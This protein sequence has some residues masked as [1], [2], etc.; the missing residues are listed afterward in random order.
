MKYHL[1]IVT[2]VL[3]LAGCEPG[4]GDGADLGLGDLN[5]FVLCEGNY[6]YINASLWR[7]EPDGETV[8]GLLYQGLTGNPLGDVAQSMNVAGDKLYIL[9]TNSHTL[10]VLW[11]GVKI[12]FET[13]IPLPG[14]GPRYMAVKGD[15]GYVTCWGL[16]GILTIDLGTHTVGKDT[17]KL[18]GKPE[19]IV[20]DGENIYCALVSRPDWTAAD[21]VV[22]IS[23][24][25]GT[26]VDS[27]QVV[28]GPTRLLVEAGKLYVASLY[29]DANYYRYAGSSVIDLVTGTVSLNDYGPTVA[30][31]EDLLLFK[32]QVYRQYA[33]GVAP[34]KDDLEVD[35]GATIG[36]LEG[37]YSAAAWGDYLFFGLTDY[38]A[39]DEVVLVD[40]DGNR[41]QS[42]QVGAL[43][44]SFVFYQQ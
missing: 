19:D 20:V 8:E 4:S 36:T 2:L 22:R 44:G 39:P 16:E 27:Y 5:G 11:L 15:T 37:V 25:T 34:L 14:A 31:G 21:Q 29:Y 1:L 9:N 23:T 26:V 40:G 38:Q 30:Y 42:Y 13:S 43:P 24:V 10:E 6:G 18:A 28:P 35:G 12:G 41:I 33:G 17:I 32:G 3:F 7:F